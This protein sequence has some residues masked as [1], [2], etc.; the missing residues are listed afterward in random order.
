MRIFSLLGTTS[1]NHP[2]AGNFEADNEGSFELPEPIAHELL[3]VHLAGKKA[4]ETESERVVRLAKAE[5]ER[6][7][8]PATLLATVAALAEK[9]DG[10]MTGKPAP[11]PAPASTSGKSSKK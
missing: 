6:L 1:V 2:D 9:I 7:R 5:Q 10:K 11:T 4:W 8:D 3:R